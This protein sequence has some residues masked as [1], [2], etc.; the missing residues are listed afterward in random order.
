MSTISKLLKPLLPSRCLI[1]CRTVADGRVCSGCWPN[2]WLP[3]HS[4]WFAYPGESL[5]NTLAMWSYSDRV[6]TLLHQVKFGPSYNLACRVG[7]EIASFGKGIITG[8]SYDLLMPVPVSPRSLRRRGFSF[9]AV[10]AD[11]LS[12]KL[13]LPTVTN[14]ISASRSHAP[15][16]QLPRQKRQKAATKIYRLRAA[17]AGQ[18][19][20]GKKI[21]LV[22]DVITTGATA[23]SIAALLLL[24]GAAYVD[25]ITAA[26][27]N[28]EPSQQV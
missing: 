28:L 1:C 20:A 17:G 16:S 21:L 7:D 2:A 25:L 15:L 3:V 18:R 23:I 4:R 22:D 13:K 11:Q 26:R 19:L 12:Q 9:P 6:V 8:A 14:L 24:E 5:R 10:L 27:A